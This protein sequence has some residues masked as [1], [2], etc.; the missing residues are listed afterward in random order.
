MTTQTEEATKI[1]AEVWDEGR[2]VVVHCEWKP[3]DW[4]HAIRADVRDGKLTLWLHLEDA[5]EL[6]RKLEEALT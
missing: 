6:H 4:E 5:R 1:E 3:G 2:A